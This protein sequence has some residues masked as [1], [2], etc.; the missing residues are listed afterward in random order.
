MTFKA[1]LGAACEKNQT[2][3]CV[4]LDPDPALMPVHCIQEFNR[5]IV[6]ATCDLVCAFKPNLAFYEAAG[7]TGIDALADT[8]SYIHEM[9]PGVIVL[10]DAK[11]G[12]IGSTSSHYAKALFKTWNFDAAT[13]NAYAGQDAIQPFLNY[14]NKGTFIWCRSSNP[15]AV[16]FQDLS[17][18]SIGDEDQKPHVTLHQQIANRA[19]NWD[20]YGNVGLVVGATYPEELAAVRAECP[21]MPILAPAVGAQA[22]NLESTVKAGIDSKGRNLIISSSRSIIYASRRKSDYRS[23]ARMAAENLRNDINQILQENGTPW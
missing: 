7:T 17:I 1:K 22:G 18:I 13:V 5:A 11:R 23:A 15:G 4:G 8:V 16:E 3:L 9:S 20:V 12:D 19:R 10:G 14:A 2:L 6:D 21:D